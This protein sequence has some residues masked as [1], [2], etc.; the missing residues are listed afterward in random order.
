[1]EFLLNIMIFMTI[2]SFA[3]SIGEQAECSCSCDKID[4]QQLG[5]STWYLLHEIA[6]HTPKTLENDVHFENLMTSLS[7]LYPCE[8][9]REHME[10]N[11]ETNIVHMDSMSMCKFHN[12]I[13]YQLNKPIYN[14][15]L[16]IK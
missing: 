4:K 7:H 12:M 3:Y 2:Y 5:R 10:R 14:C 8:T 13:N 6:A 1:M 9:C 16:I 11:L 15:S